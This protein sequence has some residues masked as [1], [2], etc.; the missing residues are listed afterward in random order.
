MSR[1]KQEPKTRPV[2]HAVPVPVTPAEQHIMWL[3]RQ[4]VYLSYAGLVSAFILALTFL[5]AAT[6]LIFCGHEVGGTVL[7]TVDL[8]AL[9]TVFITGRSNG[10]TGAGKS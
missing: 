10:P 5:G 9:V 7:G 6:S 4:E 2:D 1:A 8:V 3:N